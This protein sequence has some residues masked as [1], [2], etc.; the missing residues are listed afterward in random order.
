MKEEI[1]VNE[2][3][4]HWHDQNAIREGWMALHW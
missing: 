4:T 2:D 1:K 3:Q